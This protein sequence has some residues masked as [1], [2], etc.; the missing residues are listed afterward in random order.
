MRWIYQ[1]LSIGFAFTGALSP[2][3]NAVDP[4]YLLLPLVS[5]FPLFALYK[6]LLNFAIRRASPEK[7]RAQTPEH[8]R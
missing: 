3:N 8:L 7:H 1:G 4:P 6:L 2:K 5:L